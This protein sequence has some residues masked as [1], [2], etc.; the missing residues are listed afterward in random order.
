[1]LTMTILSVLLV[2]SFAAIFYLWRARDIA[3]R[4]NMLLQTEAATLREKAKLLEQQ[5]AAQAAGKQE[6]NESFK[7]LAATALESSMQQFLSLAQTTFRQANEIHKLDSDQ[8]HKSMDALMK[9]VSEAL[10]RYQEQ[11]GS[12]EKERA[13]A[14]QAIDMELKRVSEANVSLAK[15]TTALKDALKKPHVRG[16]WGEVQLRNCI[17]LAGMSEHSD[18]SFQNVTSDESGRHIPDMIV[19]MPGG[20]SVIVDAKTPIDAFL[21]SLE[22]PT[23]EIRGTE[24]ARHGRHVKDHVKKLSARG[25]TEVIK[26]S[27]DFTVMFLPNESFLYAALEVEPDIVEFALQKKVLIATPP[28]LIGLLKVIRFGWSEQKLAENAQRIS[29]VGT[30]LHKRLCDFVDSYATVGKHIDKAKE[31]YD[32]GRSRLE[33]RVLVQARKFEA[34][35]AKSAKTLLDAPGESV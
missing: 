29:E 35:G 5:I 8:R 10:G 34:L 27:A 1:M 14:F 28:T 30:E 31:E 24:L 22:A 15:E 11:I 3:F 17:E 21:N 16:R 9:P 18:V 6:L 32:K 20:R 33:S 25:Y 19:R 13:R 4:E 23:D 26:D 2:L 12:L 7:G